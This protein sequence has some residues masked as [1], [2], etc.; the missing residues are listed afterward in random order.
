MEEMT[1]ESEESSHQNAHIDIETINSKS[2]EELL[3]EE[4]AEHENPK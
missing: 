1:D 2:Y 3:E 4:L